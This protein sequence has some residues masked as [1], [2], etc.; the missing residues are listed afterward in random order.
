MSDRRPTLAELSASN[1]GLAGAATEADHDG[2]KP[3]DALR[4]LPQRYFAAYDTQ[5]VARHVEL[6]CSLSFEEPYALDARR[7]E[8]DVLELT[9]ASID[10]PGMLSLLAGV[11]GA[12]GF[13]IVSGDVFTL[14]RQ[15]AEY[16]SRRRRGRRP[17]TARRILPTRR[18]IDRFEGRLRTDTPQ[19]RFFSEIAAR[20]DAVIPLILP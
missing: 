2:L 20:L 12:S 9:I 7:G 13:V 1:P 3:A 17:T 19:D 15:P 4:R 6:L 8:G 5:T 14:E 11:L 10:D 18:I 16:D